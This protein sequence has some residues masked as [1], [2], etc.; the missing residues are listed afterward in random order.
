MAARSRPSGRPD[1]AGL[2]FDVAEPGEYRLEI[3]LR[4]TIR[5][6]VGPAGF[7]LAVPRVAKSRLELTL[8]PAHRRWRCRRPAA[9]CAWKKTRR[10][11]WP[12]SV[13]PT[14]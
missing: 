3:L 1:G 13:R 14:A 9:P 7:D 8:P 5:G 4:P 2:A 12:I 6:T 11:W 10:V